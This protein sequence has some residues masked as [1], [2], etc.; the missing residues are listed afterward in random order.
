M[1]F[2]DNSNVTGIVDR[3]G[4]ARTD[5]AP[6]RR[7]R[8][9]REAAGAHAGGRAGARH[10]LPPDDQPPPEIAALPLRNQ[11][12]LRDALRAACGAGV[13]KPGPGAP[14]AGSPARAGLG[15]DGS[16]LGLA[17]PASE[18]RCSARQQLGG[19]LEGEPIAASVRCLEL[20]RRRGRRPGSARLQAPASR[21]L[22]HWTPGTPARTARRGSRVST[23]SIRSSTSSTLSMPATPRSPSRSRAS[24]SRARS[25]SSIVAGSARRCGVELS[26]STSIRPA[27]RSLEAAVQLRLEVGGHLAR[28]ADDQAPKA[29]LE[30][31]RALAHVAQ[32][33]VLLTSRS[34]GRSALDQLPR[35]SCWPNTVSWI[36]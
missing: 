21:P 6:H 17:A 28:A 8:P 10:R 31:R 9:A 30:W 29:G 18:S 5:R 26:T 20:D 15:N 7:P 34:R 22:V 16:A 19:L 11:R 14:M 25:S 2:C 12:A 32:V 13:G 36:C 1:L 35:S 27:R 3:L 4:G 23:L 24:D 33:V